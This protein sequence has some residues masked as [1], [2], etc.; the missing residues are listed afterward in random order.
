MGKLSTLKP[1]LSTLPPRIGFAPG[2]EKARDRHRAQTQH[3]R[4]WYK[5]AR[6][7]RLRKAVLVRDLYTCQMA[8]CGRVGGPMVCDH[9]QPHRGDPALFWD[10][11][12]LQALCKPCHDGA[13]QA[14]ER[15]HA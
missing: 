6:W 12:N 8:G 2:D 5:T 13:K 4:A 9:K 7:E 3:W 15:K 10:E 1:T 11:R 14:E